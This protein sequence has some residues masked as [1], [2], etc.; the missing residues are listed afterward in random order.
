MKIKRLSIRETLV[1]GSVLWW[2]ATRSAQEAMT[3]T[4]WLNQE[5]HIQ[6]SQTAG[7]DVWI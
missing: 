4:S 6:R 1:V 7:R 5:T 2:A 3:V